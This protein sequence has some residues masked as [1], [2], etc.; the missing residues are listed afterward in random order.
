MLQ[1]SLDAAA[2]RPPAAFTFKLLTFRPLNPFSP[3]QDIAQIAPVHNLGALSLDSQPLRHSLRA[4]A[5]NWKVHFSRNIHKKA[6][7][8]L[9]VCTG[10]AQGFVCSHTSRA[11]MHA[12]LSQP[13]APL[14][15][16]AASSLLPLLLPPGKQAF[17]Q[18]L[19]ELTARL[20]RRI[21]DLDDVKAVVAAL[22][23]VRNSWGDGKRKCG[24]T[25]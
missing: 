20:G 19:R 13:L 22:R 9:A 17:D 10:V 1:C 7:A 23:E 11:A 24:W 5:A 21:E 14:L 25:T 2:S 6:A 8:D 15:F 4:E 18:Y 3:E 12:A 16:D